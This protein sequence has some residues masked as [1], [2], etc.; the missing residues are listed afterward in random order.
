[1]VIFVFRRGGLLMIEKRSL[2]N[3][4]SFIRFN[5]IKKEL[6]QES[7]SHGICSITYLSKIENE[8]IIPNQEIIELLLKRLEIEIEDELHIYDL[9]NHIRLLI[10]KVIR[11]IEEKKFTEVEKLFKEIKENEEMILSNTNI[12]YDYCV[13]K[14]SYFVL[15][16]N[17]EQAKKVIHQLNSVKDLLKPEL[18]GSFLH[19]YGVYK[20]KKD[21]YAE[22]LSLLQEAET[23]MN[24]SGKV[25]P[26]ILYHLS[27]TFSHLK[28][29]VLAVYY[30]N[31]SLKIY[32]NQM[33]YK[34]IIDCKMIIGINYIRGESWEEARKEFNNILKVAEAINDQSVM[35]TSHHNLAYLYSKEGEHDKA[36]EN[37]KLSL[38][39]KDVKNESYFITILF[40]ISHLQN[41]KKFEECYDKLEEV[42]QE[43]QLKSYSSL[44]VQLKVLWFEVAIEMG[45]KGISEII[46]Y[47]EGEAIPYFLEKSDQNQLSEYF[48]KLGKYNYA[49]RK[50]KLA[51]EY[52]EKSYSL[53]V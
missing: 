31:E 50:Y 43:E 41:M 14:L 5:R 35:A 17:L 38:K 29:G 27:L 46:S 12:I 45:I 23:I 26:S 51:S 22:G 37:Y 16:D 9:V 25:I 32:S 52:F 3:L 4:G 8:K 11:F 44:A 24:Q 33:N 39:L 34:R 28:N 21:K 13:L 48:Y 36:L 19:Y 7:L 47:L 2:E 30:A 6:T 20:C 10:D 49:S 42:L 40:L 1:M 15:F 18:K 53:K